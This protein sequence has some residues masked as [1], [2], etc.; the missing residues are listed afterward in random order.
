[1]NSD[2]E[3]LLPLLQAGDRKAF[4]Q[5]VRQHHRALLAAARP[6]VGVDEAEEVVQIAWIKAHKALPDF[7][8]RSSLRTWLTRIVLNEA[9]MQLRSRRKEVLFAD[10]GSA[11]DEPMA[12]RFTPSGMWAS[13]PVSWSESSPDALLMGEQLGDCIEAL[14]GV[15]PDNQRMLLELRDASGMDFGEICNTLEISASNARVLLHRARTRLFQLVDH[16]EETG[17]C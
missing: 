11:E 13:P 5:L 12:D 17:E 4:E 3:T 16:Y 2:D 10:T 14:L 8:G 6:L 7:E 15:M 9:R 1:L